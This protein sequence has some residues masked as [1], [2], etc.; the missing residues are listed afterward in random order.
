[1]SRPAW[2]ISDPSARRTMDMMVIASMISMRPTPARAPAALGDA[3]A[4][5]PGFGELDLLAI[6]V[7]PHSE[8]GGRPGN[9]RREDF[10]G[11]GAA[12]ELIQSI[13]RSRSHVPCPKYGG[14]AGAIADH[15]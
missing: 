13:V 14:R 10:Q 7:E 4:Y 2:N 12:G 1:M 3:D 8:R 6:P 15:V 9:T 11:S 5:L